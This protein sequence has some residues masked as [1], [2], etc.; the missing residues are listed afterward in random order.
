MVC[1]DGAQAENKQSQDGGRPCARLA[2]GGQYRGWAYLEVQLSTAVV[3]WHLASASWV[4]IVAEALIGELLQ[5]E[6]AV[7]QSTGL[8]VLPINHVLRLQGGGAANGAGL[9]AVVLHVEGDA[10]VALRLVEHGVHVEEPDH[11]FVDFQALFLADLG[12]LGAVDNVAEV[13][14][15]AVRGVRRQCVGLHELH[16]RHEWHL[17]VAGVDSEVVA[18]CEGA[19]SLSQR[20]VRVAHGT[21]KHG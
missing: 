16:V 10:A 14:H 18:C 11:G 6:A 20:P 3:N 4:S 21:T 9:L 15:N 12:I 17:F 13:V 19:S 5:A 7:H 8:T 1:N 2:R